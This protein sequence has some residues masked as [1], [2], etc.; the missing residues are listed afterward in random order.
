MQN[1]YFESYTDSLLGLNKSIKESQYSRTAFYYEDTPK[2][3]DTVE[4]S[5][6]TS[7]RNEAFSTKL[8]YVDRE[9][10][11]HTYVKL[12]FSLSNAGKLLIPGIGMEIVLSHNANTLR[13]LGKKVANAEPKMKFEKLYVCVTRYHLS[14]EI[15]L[16]VNARLAAGALAR[17]QVSRTRYG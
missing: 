11:I 2:N 8:K 13:L 3:Y 14:D 16:A 1:F 15:Y 7:L 5:R 4:D 6:T 12:P 10:L 17:Y 9:Q